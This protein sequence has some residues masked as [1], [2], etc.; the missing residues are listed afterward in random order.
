MGKIIAKENITLDNIFTGPSGDEGNIVSWAMPGI[1]DSS[2]D[3]LKMF[4]NADAILMGR[5]T[6]EGFS[7]FWPFQTGDWADA[8]NKTKKYVVSSNSNLSEVHWGDYSNTITL[9]D[10]DAINR[11]AQLK[12]E[13]HGTIIVTASG[14]LVQ[15]LINAELLDEIQLLIN[16]VIL[17]SGKRY[18]D[19][20]NKRNDMKLIYSKIYEKSG[21]ILLRYAFIH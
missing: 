6:Y 20:I 8:M 13:I 18:L 5:V 1:V 3:D 14:K 16:P 9:L 17:G 11:V 2:E 7:N 15:N 21:A 4:Q 19:N 10:N 12:K